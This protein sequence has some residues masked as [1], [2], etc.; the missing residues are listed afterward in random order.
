MWYVVLPPALPG[1]IA[2]AIFTFIL[3][4]NDFMAAGGMITVPTVAFFV[5]I[6]RHLIQG[7]GAGGV[8]G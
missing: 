8:K 3:A 1:L 5:A 6:Q 7:R 4:W 2:A